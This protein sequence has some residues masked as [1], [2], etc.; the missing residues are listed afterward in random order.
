MRA[1]IATTITIAG[2]APVAAFAASAAPLTNNTS[3]FT[4]IF[5]GF[6]ALIVLAQAVPA[7]LLLTGMAKG[8]TEVM[9]GEA[10]HKA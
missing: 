7:I 6:C 3:L 1:L 8:V 10:T 5:L 2:F 4:W 9:T